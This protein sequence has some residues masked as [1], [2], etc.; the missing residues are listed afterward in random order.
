MTGARAARTERERRARAAL[1]E[2]RGRCKACNGLGE[3][4]TLVSRY[5][6]PTRCHNCNGTGRKANP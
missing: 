6:A 3:V 4:V 2:V 5:G 1:K